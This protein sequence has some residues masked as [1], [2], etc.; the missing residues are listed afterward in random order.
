MLK[1]LAVAERERISVDRN[2][3][4]ACVQGKLVYEPD[5]AVRP[6]TSCSGSRLQ[7]C[8]RW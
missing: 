7:A 1:Q 4:A 5:I 6:A 2:G 3:L 8:A